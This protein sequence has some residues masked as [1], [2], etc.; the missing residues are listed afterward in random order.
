MTFWPKQAPGNLDPLPLPCDYPVDSFET[1]VETIAL[2]DRKYRTKFALRALNLADVWDAQFSDFML[3]GSTPRRV[4]LS[5]PEGQSTAGGVQA[6]QSI[7]LV[8]EDPTKGILVAGTV[9]GVG[10]TAELR[11]FAYL[12]EAY[13]LRFNRPIDVPAGPYQKFLESAERLL[14]TNGLN[15]T[16]VNQLPDATRRRY[17]KAQPESTS[18]SAWVLL[19]FLLL[20]AVGVTAYLFFEL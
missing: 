15:V 7:S 14:S 19:V 3:M 6:L 13:R 20:A 5:V 12:S 17:Q 8:P 2:E 16:V 4:T 9:D 10:Q 18:G 1:M 11:G